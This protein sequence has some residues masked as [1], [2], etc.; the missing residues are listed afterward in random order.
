MFRQCYKCGV[1]ICS[2]IVAPSAVKNNYQDKNEN[3]TERGWDR[4]A[5]IFVIKQVGKNLCIN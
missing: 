1:Y 2:A 5:K 3:T 4:I